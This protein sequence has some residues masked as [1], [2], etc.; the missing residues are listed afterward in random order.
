MNDRSAANSHRLGA[1]I[2]L[3]AG[4]LLLVGFFC[5]H[6]FDFYIGTIT[7]ADLVKIANFIGYQQSVC[8]L[9]RL[10]ALCGAGAGMGCSI[11]LLTTPESPSIKTI[12]LLIHIFYI[13]GLLPY[14]LVAVMSVQGTDGLLA[15]TGWSIAYYIMVCIV[16]LVGDLFL[17]AKTPAAASP[18]PMD[19]P[20]SPAEPMPPVEP[21]N[22]PVRQETAPALTLVLTRM[23]TQQHFTIGSGACPVCLGRSAE[24]AIVVP[25]NNHVARRH[26]QILFRDG[27][28]FLC[29]LGAVNKTYLNDT[30]LTPEQPC[31]LK[32]GDYITLADEMFS[33]DSIGSNYPEEV[34]SMPDCAVYAPPEYFD[35]RDT[36]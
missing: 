13:V 15:P 23:N 17:T 21:D 16:V 10:L 29:D 34:S 7:L 20:V 19:T 35:R 26:A 12:T 2:T 14:L 24:C 32:Q 33:V 11:Y 5:I 1:G 22:A 4:A 30:C 8:N 31:A 36:Q 9:L 27:T 3:F 6:I 28:F 25:D 18:A